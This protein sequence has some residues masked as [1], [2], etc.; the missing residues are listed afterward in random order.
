MQFVAL[1]IYHKLHNL[2]ISNATH[3]PTVHTNCRRV[4]QG[5]P[6]WK[7]LPL[8]HADVC[9][10]M[11][12]YADVCLPG[13]FKKKVYLDER[14]YRWRMLTYADACWR[15][16]TYA[17][18]ACLTRSWTSTRAPIKP[19]ATQNSTT[20]QH[21]CGALLVLSSEHIKFSYPSSTKAG[22]NYTKP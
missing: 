14:A 15:M 19:K 17:C 8:T 2:Y 5:V 1:L 12:T 11:L 4:H 7:S 22:G 6:R 9:W 13:V 16:L 3:T 20:L 18:Q 21:C 10:R